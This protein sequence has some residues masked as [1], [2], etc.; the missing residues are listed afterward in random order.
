MRRRSKGCDPAPRCGSAGRSFQRLAF[1]TRGTTLPWRDPPS[2]PSPSRA[3]SP[4]L[5]QNPLGRFPRTNQTAFA[6]TSWFGCGYGRSARSDIGP[7][8]STYTRRISDRRVGKWSIHMASISPSVASTRKQNKRTNERKGGNEI[9]RSNHN[10]HLSEPDEHMVDL[11]MQRLGEPRFEA[12]S[13]QH[14]NERASSLVWIWMRELT[15]SVRDS[16]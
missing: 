2:V 1:S 14:V 6:S 15:S 3:R 4:S 5:V 13:G 8:C 7:P 9:Q 12:E 11:A 16:L 10:P